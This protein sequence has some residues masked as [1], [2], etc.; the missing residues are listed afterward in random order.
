MV[1]VLAPLCFVNVFARI[2]FFEILRKEEYGPGVQN[3]LLKLLLA[4]SR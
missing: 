1:K 3:F 4:L 2:A